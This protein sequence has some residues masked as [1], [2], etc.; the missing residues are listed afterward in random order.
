M[1]DF[2]NDKYALLVIAAETDKDAVD[3]YKKYGFKV[4]SLGEKYLGVERFTCV[5]ES[6]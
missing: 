3:F 2:I 1:I 5:L 6:R 4:S